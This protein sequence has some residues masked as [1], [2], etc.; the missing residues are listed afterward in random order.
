MYV[1]SPEGLTYFDYTKV[2]KKS[3]CNLLVTGINVS[4]KLLPADTNDFVLKHVDNSIIFQ[5]VGISYKS[6][7]KIIYQYRMLGLDTT[8]RTTSDLA[9]NYPSL[10]SGS[11]ELQLK[12]INKFDVQSNLVSVRFTISK[13]LWE[14]NWSRALLLVVFGYI[15]W[16]VINRRVKLIQKRERERSDTVTK[17][18][19]LEQMALKS[20][21]NP[22]FIFNC[23]N[24]IQHYVIDKDIIGANDFI[25]K[26]SRLI[27]LTLDNSSKTYINLDDEINYLVIYMELEQ[28]RFE[29]K[30]SFEIKTESI[31][32][33]EYFIPPMIL[34]PYIEN[35]IRHGVRYR[36]DDL[37]KII[38]R[39]LRNENYLVVNISDNGIGRKLS[40]EYKSKSPIEYQSKG[41]ELTAKR[42]EMF[43]KTHSPAIQILINDLENEQHEASGTEVIIS[44]PLKHTNKFYSNA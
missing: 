27:R 20:Q 24:S 18:V 35:A 21:M 16:A 6:A 2:F 4:G 26:F 7:G 17:I 25:A 9:L 44:F 41:M 31:S 38:I 23:L 42:I 1:G 30:F 39:I 8:W 13:T 3:I 40:Q 12:A 33:Q 28:Q 11:Y 29:N 22:H 5:F 15:L 10:S 34:Q 43:N 32:K 36:S 37:G 14:E 19:E